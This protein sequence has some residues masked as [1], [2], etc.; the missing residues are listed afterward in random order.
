M[1]SSKTEVRFQQVLDVSHAYEWTAK[2]AQEHGIR[3]QVTER[4]VITLQRTAAAA[5]LPLFGNESSKPYKPL[6]R[7]LH[8][9]PIAALPPLPAMPSSQTVSPTN[10]C[11]RV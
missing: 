4:N 6:H 1:L 5:P 3:R 7:C 2:S 11:S 8:H 10:R 9:S